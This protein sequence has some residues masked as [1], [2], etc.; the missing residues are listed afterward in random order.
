[1][2]P[3][4]KALLTKD[5][6]RLGELMNVN[7]DLQRRLGGSMEENERLIAVALEAGAWGAKLAGAGGGGTVIALHPHPEALARAFRR[8]GARRIIPL[9]LAPGLAAAS[10]RATALEEMAT[11]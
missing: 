9:C 3:A 7:H 5:W 2:P 8:A 4:K 10:M 11:E 1:V 6:P